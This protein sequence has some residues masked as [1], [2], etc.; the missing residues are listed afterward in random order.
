MNWWKRKFSNKEHH[1]WDSFSYPEGLKAW[2]G[3]C[4]LQMPVRVDRGWWL[5]S[6]DDTI[7]SDINPG[8]WAR[9]CSC[10]C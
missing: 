8:L 3:Q 4:G 2:G 1:F 6:S 7:L 5:E 10:R 9:D